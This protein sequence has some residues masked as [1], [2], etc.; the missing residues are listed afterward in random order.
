MC[1]KKTNQEILNHILELYKENRWEDCQALLCDLLK[2]VKGQVFLHRLLADVYLQQRRWEKSALEYKKSLE[3]DPRD[4][5]LYYHLAIVL[6][7]QDQDKEALSFCQKALHLRPDFVEALF[8]LGELFEKKGD[9][10]QAIASYCALLNLDAKHKKAY[11]QLSSLYRDLSDLEKAFDVCKKALEELAHDAHILKAYIKS[12]VLLLEKNLSQKGK[13]A[14]LNLYEKVK[15]SLT[16][17]LELDRTI[18]VYFLQKGHMQEGFLMWTKRY[19]QVI[20]KQKGAEYILK[21]LPKDLRGKGICLMGDKEL[22]EQVFLLRFA[23]ELKKRQ[24]RVIL[25][26]Q[27]KIASIFS[28]LSWVDRVISE[29]SPLGQEKIA[30]KTYMLTDLPFLLG[31]QDP[32]DHPPL[33]LSAQTD[34]MQ[35]AYGVLGSFG[36]PPYFGISWRAG[37]Y[38]PERGAYRK[39][40]PLEAFLKTFSSLKCTWVVLQRYP[41]EGELELLEKYGL[42]FGD[43]SHYNEDLEGMLGVLSLLDE[44]LGV[45]STNVHLRGSLDKGDRVFVPAVR[46]W[47]WS[48]RQGICYWY[49]KSKVYL[50][51]KK[52]S[53]EKAFLC[54]YKDL[55]KQY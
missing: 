29:E 37:V 11:L 32:L 10:T 14:Y 30:D 26:T 45:S 1:A 22:G 7:K 8:F 9:P 25:S 33:Q 31:V 20:K 23:K 50:Q 12:S 52:G 47:L 42:R 41:L 4:A 34:A 24:A 55:K 19:P 3:L 49:P 6:E 46:D 21:P 51:D 39:E 54:L 17:T 2:Q 38:C 18:A 16:N 15:L 13:K 40:I 28:R 5:D 53:W 48:Q 36:P 27:S 44:H 43:C 35:R